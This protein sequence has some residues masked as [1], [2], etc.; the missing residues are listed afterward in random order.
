MRGLGRGGAEGGLRKGLRVT[1]AAKYNCVRNTC[2]VSADGGGVTLKVCQ[3]ICDSVAGP[4][5]QQQQ[6]QQRQ[7]Q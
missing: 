3:S 1:P 4:S 7:Q 2:E 6:R 5:W